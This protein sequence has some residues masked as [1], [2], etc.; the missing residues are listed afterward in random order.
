MLHLALLRRFG[1]GVVVLTVLVAVPGVSAEPPPKV[2]LRIA[3]VGTGVVAI[4]AERLGCRTR[5]SASYDL[6]T[7]VE[8]RAVPGPDVKFERWTGDCVG[9]ATGCAVALDQETTVHAVFVGEP[10]RVRVTVGGPATIVSEPKGLA[11][12]RRGNACD[13]S[14]PHGSIIR[15]KPALERPRTVV[16]GGACRAVK[17]R[18]CRLYVGGDMEVAAAFRQ[19]ASPPG[20]KRLTVRLT[21][22]RVTSE[23]PGIDCP[24]ACQGSFAR[25]AVVTLR[26]STP[27]QWKGGCV[28][29]GATCKVVLDVP[30]TIDPA[31]LPHPAPGFGVNV[32][33]SGRGLVL[34]RGIRCGATTGTLLDCESF[35]ARGATVVLEAVPEAGIRFAGWRG[36]CR[37]TEPRCTLRA[38]APKIVFALFRR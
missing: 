14:F 23:P 33:V 35:F 20:P 12:G 6:G 25:R 3:V 28:G 30:V 34:G 27:L 2:V 26:A 18:V 37:G 10:R 11:C 17:V 15:L 31:T 7:V 5:C 4:P 13:A 36:F 16:W 9:T 32:S 1:L 21:D 29:I 8:L 19:A 38:T 24:G 22:S